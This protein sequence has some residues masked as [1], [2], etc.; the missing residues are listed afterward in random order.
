MSDSHILNTKKMRM[1]LLISQYQLLI[2]VI[3]STRC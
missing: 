1:S 3:T 2:M